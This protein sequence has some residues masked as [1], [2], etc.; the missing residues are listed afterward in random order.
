MASNNV[1]SISD[2]INLIIMIIVPFCFLFLVYHINQ[3]LR[4]KIVPCD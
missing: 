2:A 1:P 3:V 4:V